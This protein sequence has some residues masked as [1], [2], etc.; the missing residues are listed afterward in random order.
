MTSLNVSAPT[1]IML[2]CVILAAAT[3]FI[4]RWEIAVANT[5]GLAIRL[6]RWTGHIV[7]CSLS[8]DSGGSGFKYNC[9]E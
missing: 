8:R 5:P 1:A 3:L 4:F 6:D 2:G 9:G 7:G